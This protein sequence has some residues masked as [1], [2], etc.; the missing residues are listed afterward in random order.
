MLNYA[1]KSL[2]SKYSVM[3]H[4]IMTVIKCIQEKNNSKAIVLFIILKS[5]HQQT[6]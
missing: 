1:V 5:K 6:I 4:R 3:G 2:I